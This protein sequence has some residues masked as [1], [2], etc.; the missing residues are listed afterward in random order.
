VFPFAE[1]NVLLEGVTRGLVPRFLNPDKQ[2]SDEA[3]RFQTTIWSYYNDPTL[4][5]GDATATIAPSMPGS[6]YEAG[7]LLYVALG[8]FLWALLIAVVERTRAQQRTPAAVGLYVLC[9][10][11]ALAGV[12]RDY[13]M[14]MSTLLQTLLVFF[15]LCAHA[16]LVERR[17]DHVF[18]PR[19]S[20]PT[21]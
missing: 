14:A 7:G 10:V 3:L 18:H 11:Q 9:A 13:G 20:A 8:G 1:R 19:T 2:Q 16:W 17:A 12:E 15:V 6:L 5:Q 21:P 4:D